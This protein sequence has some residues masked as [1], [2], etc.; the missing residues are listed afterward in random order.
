MV[1]KNSVTLNSSTLTD[2]A[3]WK[4]Q[5]GAFTIAKVSSTAQVNLWVAAKDLTSDKSIVVRVYL[6][7]CTNGT[8]HTCTE[9]AQKQVTRPN[10]GPF[11]QMVFS[12]A[13]SDWTFTGTSYNF[14][15]DG[16]FEVKVFVPSGDDDAWISYDIQ[17][18]P[19]SLT[20][21]P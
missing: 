19:A 7:H 11:S 3:N 4:L 5:M 8:T 6:R 21:N 2:F 9:L 12:F 17:L 14:P 16:W 15:A 1:K 13:G 10:G 20:L 18:H